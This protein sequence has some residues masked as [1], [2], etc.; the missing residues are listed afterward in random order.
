[1][2]IQIFQNLFNTPKY[3]DRLLSRKIKKFNEDEWWLWG[4]GLYESNSNRIYV[5]CKTR[6]NKPFFTNDCKYY[7]GSVLAIFPKVD[8]DINTAIDYLNDVDW[9]D[10][11]FKVGGRLCYTQKSLENVYL[12]DCFKYL[13]K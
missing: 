5:N 11:G 9:N 3:K 8:M 4:R 7:D 1:M 13:I 6:D 12:P 2:K 10:L